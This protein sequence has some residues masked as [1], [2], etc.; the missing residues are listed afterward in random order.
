MQ[1]R[2]GNVYPASLTA[3]ELA[4]S[5]VEKIRKVEKPGKLAQPRLECPA[6]YAVQRRA[7]FKI[8][9]HRQRLIQHTALEHDA[10]P[11]RYLGNI[12]IRVKAGDLHAA[13]VGL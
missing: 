2:T 7:A 12:L 1:Q 4:D 8:I 11:A 5:A 10:E 6:R 13:A 9:A 3:G